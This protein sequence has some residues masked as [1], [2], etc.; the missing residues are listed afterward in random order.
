MSQS[1][2]KRYDGKEE[3]LTSPATQII[4]NTFS[5]YMQPGQQIPSDLAPKLI[6]RFN[7]NEGYTLYDDVLPLLR[8]LR[9]RPTTTSNDERVVVGVITNSDD[10]T[11]DILTSLD[12]RVNAL[13]YGGEAAPQRTE[14]CDIDFTVL[15]YD[16]GVEKPDKRIFEAAEGMIPAVL[17]SRAGGSGMEAGSESWEKVYVGDEYAK[18]VVGAL[19]AGWNAVLVDREPGDK[20]SEVEWLDDRAPGSLFEVFEIAR[21]V[22]FSSLAKLAEWLPSRP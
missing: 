14:D 7:S 11:S 8:K 4:Y 6:H 13:R 12:V 19:D 22:G 16:V 9:G 20:R 1:Q 21:A 17:Q 2:N 10:R 5:P 15:S 3:V 18:D